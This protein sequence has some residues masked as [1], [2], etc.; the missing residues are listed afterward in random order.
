ME[1]L[2]SNKEKPGFEITIRE[3]KEDLK[4]DGDK[5]DS[6]T[7][8][9]QSKVVADEDGPVYIQGLRFY[10]ICATL[11]TLL[12]QVNMEIPVVIT[13]LVAISDDLS[14]FQDVDWVV[15]SY[16]LGYVAVIV[17][18][19]KFSD[20]FGRKRMLLL[21]AFIFIIF[22]AACSA[23]QTMT[24]LIIFRALQ[25]IGGGGCWSVS[26]IM[27]NELVPA[28]KL[29][30][31]VSKFA[32]ASALAFLT[33]PIIGGAIASDISW[34]WI[35]I[36]NVPIATPAFIMGYLAIP[37]DFP[38]MGR[39]DPGSKSIIELMKKDTFNRIDFPGTA[40]ILMAT[41]LLTAGFEEVDKI[42]PWKSPYVISLLTISGL[43]WIG[44]VI[45]ERHV[46]LSDQVRE[47]VLPWRCLKNRQ[48]VGVLLTFICLG[49]P[50]IITMFILPQRFQLVYGL[51]GLDSG[52]RLMPYTISIPIGSIFAS[53][54]AGKLK[55]PPLYF[56][57]IGSSLQV[58]GLT[59]LGTMP[60]T[61]DIPARIYG[62]EVITGIGCGLCFALLFILIPF[63]NEPRD[64]AVAMG[65]GSQFRMIGCSM[66]LAIATS[67]LN[68]Y[69]RPLLEE[70]L[71]VS[72]AE[73]LTQV[74]P[75]L[76]Q[77]IQNQVRE[78]LA[79]G[80]NRQMLALCVSS[81]LQI[82]AALLMWQKKQI[83]V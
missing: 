56:L 7:D 42:F 31:T 6:D 47:P 64:S 10:F 82:P 62:F 45:W 29:A 41:V 23:S 70:L 13:A 36:I 48:M 17:I 67:V 11:A 28:E 34:R 59:L 83:T 3:S 78:I 16:L 12:F 80:Y 73:H 2:K 74:L 71:H 37:D 54:I 81:A 43:S 58:I 49:G 33:G 15:S 61:L 51:S 24:Q 69:A 53:T 79:E 46:T 60:T 35:F 40:L 55:F 27:I 30:V 39:P 4:S 77:E 26:S 14:G 72:S 63:V 20:I 76:S 8:V 65:L 25:G 21:S 9:E 38:N 1:D 32:I 68:T 5:S 18:F 44:L 57:L 52:V 66:V 50:T 22:S 75:T 19:S